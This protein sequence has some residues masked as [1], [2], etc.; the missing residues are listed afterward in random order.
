[1]EIVTIEQPDH[2]VLRK[3]AE[4][5][6][7]PLSEEHMQFALA[8]KE[9]MINLG[10]A[11]GLAATQVGK[12]WQIIAFQIPRDA[13]VRRK[14]AARMVKPTIWVNPT[15][16]PIIEDGLSTDWEGCFSIPNYMGEVPRYNTIRYEAYLVSG[17]K[18]SGVAHGFLARVIQHEIGHLNAQLYKDLLTKNSRFGLADEMIKFRHQVDK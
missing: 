9:R 11:V 1:M 7:I 8:L 12:P 18:I 6:A 16:T 4:K 15:Y 17:E 5:I 2:K 13:L 10:N 14:D 3:P